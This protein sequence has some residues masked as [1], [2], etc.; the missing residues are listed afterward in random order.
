ML[1]NSIISV[2]DDS[3]SVQSSPWQ[4]D[5]YWK[6]TNPKANQNKELEFY[7]SRLR[8]SPKYSS[9][10]TRMKGRRPFNLDNPSEPLG[11]S[12]HLINCM[13]V[14]DELLY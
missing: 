1:L 3:S 12:F 10:A 9:Q 7:F 13:I 6:Q 5:H 2:S 14:F 4:R 8:C 11:V